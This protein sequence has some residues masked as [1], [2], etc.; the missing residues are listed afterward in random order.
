MQYIPR[1]GI[2]TYFRYD[3]NKTVMI[4][5]NGGEKESTLNTD[6]FVE[7]MAGFNSGKDVITGQRISNIKELVIPAKTTLIIELSK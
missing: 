7:R 2:Y 4:A 5:Y 3:A 1:N 6:Y